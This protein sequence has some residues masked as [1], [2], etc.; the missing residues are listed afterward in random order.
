MRRW[1]YR[2]ARAEQAWESD[3]G[4]GAG[5]TSAEL[6]GVK[7]ISDSTEL[8]V[9]RAPAL[10]EFRVTCVGEIESL[11][12][13]SDPDGPERDAPYITLQSDESDEWLTLLF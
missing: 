8:G 9:R 6:S 12:K 5:C 3:D 4:F 11:L 13:A 1:D 10:C 7:S 2:A